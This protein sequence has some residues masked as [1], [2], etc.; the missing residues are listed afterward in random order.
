VDQSIG[1]SPGDFAV[2]AERPSPARW[3]A[4]AIAGVVAVAALAYVKWWPLWHKATAALATHHYKATS[5]LTGGAAVA[6]APSWPAAWSFAQ[7][8]YGAV[9]MAVIAGI[10]VAGAVQALLP[11]R[12]FQRFLADSTLKA[13]LLATAGALP[14]FF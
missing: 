8:Y 2:P 10:V 12:F 14:A 4:L 7:A 3:V 11:Q 9:W 6:P 5:I 1:A 13:T